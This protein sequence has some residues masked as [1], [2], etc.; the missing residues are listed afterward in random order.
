MADY[1][2]GPYISWNKTYTP[3]KYGGIGLKYFGA[4]NKACIA[5]I[6]W[7]IA[8]K[9]DSLWVKRVHSKYLKQQELGRGATRLHLTIVGGQRY[10][11][12]KGYQWLLGEME[13]E[14]WS[15]PIWARTATPRHSSTTWFF[16]HQ[17]LLVR[18]RMARLMGQRVEVKCAVCEEA[19]EDIDH[20]FLKCRWAR[21]YW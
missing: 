12:Q 6:V 21:E 2:K 5:K 17:K 7:V 15:K 18:S 20:M 10:T 16:I 9:K 1:Q 4:W 14:E 11:V 3:R 19:E 13:Y 8:L